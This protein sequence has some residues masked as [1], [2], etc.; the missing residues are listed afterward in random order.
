MHKL[1][2][3]KF[4]NKKI[5]PSYVGVL[6]ILA[7][8]L[9]S[10]GFII[11]RIQLA[12]QEIDASSGTFK[13]WEEITLDFTGSHNPMSET[14]TPNPFMDYRLNVTITNGIK[15]YQI[16]GYF[17]GNGSG[18]LGNK[19]R[20]HFMADS[21]GTW[22]YTADLR[23][24]TNVAVN[25]GGT[26]VPITPNSGTFVVSGESTLGGFY[27]NCGKLRY[28]GK[29]YLQCAKTGR[30]WIKGGTNSPENWLAGADTGNEANIKNALNYL[31]SQKVNNIYF[32]PNNIGGDGRGD[33]HPFVFNYTTNSNVTYDNLVRYKT[34]RLNKWNDIFKYAIE[35]DI[36]LEFVLN[37]IEDGN[38]L[39]LGPNLTNQ[40]KLFYREMVARYSHHPAVRWIITEENAFSNTN[41]ISF[42]GYIKS[43]DPYQNPI[44]VHTP[45]DYL[46]F[47]EGLIGN[48]SFDSASIQFSTFKDSADNASIF[49]E[50]WRKKSKE[51]NRS[52]VIDLDEAILKEDQRYGLR[53]E[54]MADLRKRVLY[55]GYFSG[56]NISWYYGY[57]H[58]LGIS[59]FKFQDREPMWQWMWYARKLLL[60]FP[61]IDQFIPGDEL[62]TSQNFGGG[63]AQVYY[64]P[65]KVYLIYMANT[66][67]G[68]NL[69]I[70]LNSAS[71]KA[72][73]LRW[74]NPR[75][76]EYSGSA[77]NINGSSSISINQSPSASTGDR[78]DW[79]VVIKANDYSPIQDAKAFIENNG[80]IVIQPENHPK[81]SGWT[82]ANTLS[83]FTG[84][85]Y[86]KWNSNNHISPAG[87]GLT[88]YKL[89]V[90]NPGRYELRL[91]SNKLNPDPSEDNDVWIKFN[92][93]A[94]FKAYNGN[95][96]TNSWEWNTQYEIV[97]G[98]N[99]PPAFADLT[100]GINTLYISGRSN[101]FHIDR[102]HLYLTSTSTPLALTHPESEYREIMGNELTCNSICTNNNQCSSVNQNWYCA[103]QYNFQNWANNS[104]QFASIQY[105]QG[106]QLL[107]D[108]GKITDLNVFLQNDGKL[109]QHLV[110]S[111]KIYTRANTPG[112]G[113]DQYWTDVTSN[114]SSVGCNLYTDCGGAITGFNSI[115]HTDGSMVQHLLRSTNTSSKLFTREFKTTWTSWVEATSS[116]S[117][118]GGSNAGL[119]TSFTS[120]YHR[121]G[122]IIQNL[123]RGGKV[124]ERRNHNGWSSW[125]NVTSNFDACTS[126]TTN[127]CGKNSILSFE[128]ATNQNNTD[129]MYLIRNNN[130]VYSQTSVPQNK[131]CRL[132]NNP[133]SNTCQGITTTITASI[134]AS[135]IPPTNTP[136]VV[137]SQMPPTNTPFVVS[138]Q[139]PPT[140]TP[141]VIPS[142]GNTAIPTGLTQASCTQKI[143][144]RN[145]VVV[146]NVNIGNE[147]TY[148]LTL[149]P[150]NHS[151]AILTDPIPKGLSVIQSSLPSY[152]NIYGS[153]VLGTSDQPTFTFKGSIFVLFNLG[154]LY[155]TVVIMTKFK[156]TN[157][158]KIDFL[159]KEFSRDEFRVITKVA[160]FFTVGLYSLQLYSYVEETNRVPVDS[161]ALSGF[162]V[163]CNVPA[164]IT[165]VSFRAIILENVDTLIRNTATVNSHDKE[166][167][168][169]NVLNVNNVTPVASNTPTEV[170]DPTAI[171][172]GPA[173]IN[174]NGI[175]DIFD[176]GYV[177]GGFARS[178]NKKCSDTNITYSGCGPKDIN[179][180]RTID[181]LDFAS[182]AQRYN[183]PSCL[184]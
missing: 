65:G 71:G 98:T 130:E 6:I 15:T 104:T 164:G 132:I 183:K 47:Y 86:I 173:D 89:F 49:S 10:I 67:N 30:S 169:T 129:I 125:Q 12:N 5:R 24:G 179:R 32:L 107:T 118:V 136:F 168:C 145:G 60:E 146:S 14:S 58:D 140:N 96:S 141:F 20:I 153:S 116:I 38:R 13:K 68:E 78:D 21:E 9:I 44:A 121:D 143:A 174:N 18:S 69:K 70:N 54:N 52:W 123:V 4:R 151:G 73:T 184:P 77:Q 99:I 137:P 110:K 139:M 103:S 87:S 106:T 117:G 181:I 91:R 182:F 79:V 160:V 156:N 163:S 102:I 90:S 83:G 105:Q 162:S 134:V 61:D 27:T 111:G 126:S 74:Y 131:R 28:V 59:M 149:S 66:T 53:K 17:I 25:T 157:S 167:T 35:K 62:V 150:N 56:S 92:N 135:Q 155:F 159:G 166:T 55:P 36:A 165:K 93:S 109:V 170:F 138:S 11:Q 37:E 40:R 29:H 97:H 148:E 113:W 115:M 72:L 177:N 112:Q 152:C 31:S 172:C 8:L 50:T 75:T 120:T 94:W 133:F 108:S 64:N 82:T 33:T 34:T 51:K 45:L 154:I 63:K 22:S 158:K 119:I 178:Y 124:Y 48:P 85:G 122:F 80:L 3:N 88:E 147:I 57:D 127:N 81:G 42:A 76:G 19:W 16:P 180:N 26:N 1:K 128:R 161:S 2:K 41:L 176:F 171:V 39:L 23:T 95:T 43:I 100:Q 114:V 144:L 101:G 84:S 7:L 175:F 46:D 142:I